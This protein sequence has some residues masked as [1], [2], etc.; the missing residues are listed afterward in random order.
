M[1]PTRIKLSRKKGF[2]LQAH[3]Q[4]RNGLEAV[5]VARPSK[6]GNPFKVGQD[7]D[8]KEC[9]KKFHDLYNPYRHGGAIDDYFISIANIED[10]TRD[11]HGKNLAC[12]CD[13]D[14]P[15]HADIL[16]LLANFPNGDL[17]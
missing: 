8:A 7:G 15:C 6:W 16:M 3:S 11:L 1:T 9:V 14:A 2:N 5:N 12:W 4:S 13:L 10:I 17:R